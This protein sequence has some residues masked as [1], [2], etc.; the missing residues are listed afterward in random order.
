M[1]GEGSR[2][3]GWEVGRGT[4][5]L[6]LRR[7]TDDI[8]VIS[9]M[10]FMS[11]TRSPDSPCNNSRS[12]SILINAPNFSLCF[13]KIICPS[14]VVSS[15]WNGWM[16]FMSQGSVRRV[17]SPRASPLRAKVGTEVEK[18]RRGDARMALVMLFRQFMVKSRC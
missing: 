9:P 7:K 1:L 3:S 17:S 2:W 14:E 18:V 5:W 6:V 10:F 13:S 16:F 15:N 8:V 12:C 11:A 4:L